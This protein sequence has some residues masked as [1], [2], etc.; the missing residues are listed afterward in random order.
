LFPGGILEGVDVID[1]KGNNKYKF[2]PRVLGLFDMKN[3]PEAP[4]QEWHV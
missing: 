1:G 2:T 3:F 4:K